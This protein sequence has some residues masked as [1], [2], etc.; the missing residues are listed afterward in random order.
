MHQ[1]LSRGVICALK[2]T[3]GVLKYSFRDKARILSYKRG[4]RWV[5]ALKEQLAV[6]GVLMCGEYLGVQ[7]SNL[8]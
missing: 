1:E 2:Q 7:G 6:K 8:P 5:P 4:F 3:L